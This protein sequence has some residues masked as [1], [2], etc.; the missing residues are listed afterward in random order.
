MKQ[1]FDSGGRRV[2]LWT[3]QQARKKR[4]YRGETVFPEAPDQSGSARAAMPR[5]LHTSAARQRRQTGPW[6]LRPAGLEV[7]SLL[8]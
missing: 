6:W 8:R 7:R 4:S 5:M 2:V 3:G 1:R